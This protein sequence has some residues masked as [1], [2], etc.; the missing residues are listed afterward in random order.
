M[1]ILFKRIVD[2]ASV[3][4]YL[5]NAEGGFGYVNQAAAEN[6]GYSEAELLSLS[7]AD[8]D[9]EFGP[10]FRQLW[11]EWKTRSNL[12]LE[13]IHRTKSGQIVQKEVDAVCITLGTTDYLCA[14]VRDITER[15]RMETALLESGE[16]YRDL[17]ESASDLIQFVR[18]DGSFLLVNPAWRSTFGYSA[19]EIEQLT[20]FD[21]IDPDCTNH[22]MKTFQRVMEQGRVDKI[23]TTFVAKNGAKIMIQGAANCRYENGKPQFTRCIFRNVTEEKRLQA[24]LLQSQKLEAIGRLTSGVA[25]DFN[26]LLTTIL[27]YS[28]LYLRRLPDSDPMADALRSIRDAGIR[29]AALTRQLLTFSRHQ[30]VDMRVID[31]SSVVSGLSTM[32]RRLIPPGIHFTVEVP[33]GGQ[34]RILA[35]RHQLEQVLLNLAINARDAM[36]DGGDLS[37]SCFEEALDKNRFSSFDN[38]APGRY[39]VLVVSDTGEGMTREVQE[40]IFEP[41]FTTK[42]Q[43]KGTGLGLAT[44]Y[45]IVK[46]HS[47]YVV[48]Q[49]EPGKG[50][51][52]RLYFPKVEAP[53]ESAVTCAALEVL[54]GSETILVV[55]D[56]PEILAVIRHSLEAMGYTVFTAASAE[57]ALL[58]VEDGREKIDLLLTDVVMPGMTGHGLATMAQAVDPRIRVL[59]MSGYTDSMLEEH[60]VS[61]MHANFISKPLSPGELAIKLRKMLA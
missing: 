57:E 8:I 18:P 10:R 59:F 16:Q 1:Y 55:D 27:S 2:T 7:L 12:H 17:F 29:G 53:V 19:E 52:F 3:E 43:G 32:I 6:L 28:E 56:E 5:I 23:E 38:I 13:T 51:T 35:D 30:V 31:L 26:N 44:A 36:A 61:R 24:Q 45:G 47:G 58:L 46:Q 42:P 9:P 60:G 41:F 14:F 11:P 4:F 50:T 22:C 33:P 15:K 21:L 40:H 37:I 49:S 20:I 25:H 39:V 54:Q 34:E 48:V